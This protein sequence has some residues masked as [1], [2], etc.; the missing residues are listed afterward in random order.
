MTQY[1]THAASG[2]IPSACDDEPRTFTAE[3]ERYRRVLP[4]RVALVLQA[5]PR[6]WDRDNYDDDDSL[7]SAWAA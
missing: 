6:P 1:M 5:H 2:K 4:S 3:E 7:A